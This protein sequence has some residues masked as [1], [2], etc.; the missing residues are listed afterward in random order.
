MMRRGEC[1]NTEMYSADMGVLAGAPAS[2]FVHCQENFLKCRQD[3]DLW[4][5]LE[6]WATWCS[7]GTR[8]E[9]LEVTVVGAVQGHGGVPHS[10]PPPLGAGVS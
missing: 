10:R 9:H 8:A 5:S 2:L 6:R 1:I 3:C 4:L 7:C